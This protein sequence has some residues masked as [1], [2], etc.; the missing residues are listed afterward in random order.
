MYCVTLEYWIIYYF[1]CLVFIT[2]W[3]CLHQDEDVRY[4]PSR[5][6]QGG[7]GAYNAYISAA[8]RYAALG[9]PTLYDHPGSAYG[10]K[11]SICYRFF[12]RSEYTET[13]LLSLVFHCLTSIR[14]ILWI[15]SSSGQEDICWETS[16]RSKHGWPKA[17]LWQIW[18]NRRY[19]HSEGEAKTSTVLHA[20]IY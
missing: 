10:S 7:Y 8:T 12:V 4:P 3:K 9:A 13:F 6:S 15:L 14:R 19:I 16:T 18:S 20:I 5:P 11:S 1:R 2:A 17:L